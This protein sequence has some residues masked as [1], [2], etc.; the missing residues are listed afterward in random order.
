[1]KEVISDNIGNVDWE[2]TL[3]ENNIFDRASYRRG[4]LYIAY[5]NAS[6][7]HDNPKK[8]NI[9][10][11]TFTIYP[12]KIIV[13]EKDDGGFEARLPNTQETLDILKESLHK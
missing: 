10:N 13:E 12:N 6:L 3:K 9:N 1:M 4:C 5:I 2:T 8:I 7:R 11:Y